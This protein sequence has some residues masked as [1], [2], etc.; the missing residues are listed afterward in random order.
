MKIVNADWV[1]PVNDVA[2]AEA[3]KLSRRFPTVSYEDIHSEMW[4]WIL[5][6][7]EKVA[8]TLEADPRAL[9][10]YLRTEGRRYALAERARV[11]GYHVQDL[12]FYTTAQLYGLLPVVFDYEDW[13][14]TGITG[15][16]G[17]PK[18]KSDPKTGGNLVAMLA[19]VSQGLL[20]LREHDYN[21]I[22]WRFKYDLSDEA[23]ALELECT[24]Q[25]VNK[26]IQ[27]AV[28]SLQNVLGGSSPF[29]ET[30]GQRTAISNAAARARTSQTYEGD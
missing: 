14:P 23:I 21:I 4:V 2:S 5:D 15:D 10:F 18:G 16:V 27:R 20:S 17:Q 11:S 13:Q 28:K 12:Y 3:A 8:E 9:A 29:A 30:T 22:V 25:A 19:D 7:Q 26:K 1:N 6:H 24:P